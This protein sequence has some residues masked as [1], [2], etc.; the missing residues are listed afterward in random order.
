MIALVNQLYNN[1]FVK[2]FNK[3]L[4]WETGNI[5][6]MFCTPAFILDM[7]HNTVSD[8]SGEV[9][10]GSYQAGGY[11]LEERVVEVNSQ[12]AV[13]KAADLLLQDVTVS[14][15]RYVVIYKDTG[16][17]A[18]SPLL[19]VVDLEETFG[20]TNGNFMVKF[21]EAGIVRFGQV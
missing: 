1:F 19:C 2:L 16:D 18:T 6:C 21:D 7:S 15:V 8:I 20:V 14:D 13:L 9:Q 3:E 11:V 10:G 4:G 12:E 17:P 5:K